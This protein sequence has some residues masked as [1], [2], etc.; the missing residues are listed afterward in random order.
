MDNTVYFYKKKSSSV[1]YL[2]LSILLMAILF[3][4]T[5]FMK[6]V[7]VFNR[8]FCGLGFLIFGAATL[9]MAKQT[10][11][12]FKKVPCIT[13]HNDRLIS[14]PQMDQNEN[15]V[16]VQFDEVDRLEY[17]TYTRH[18][19]RA[20]QRTKLHMIAVYSANPA[21]FNARNP[22]A[23]KLVSS[24]SRYIRD[25]I[26]FMIPLDGIVGGRKAAIEIIIDT[27][28]RYKSSQPTEYFNQ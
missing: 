9:V 22:N 15:Q 12:A 10:I 21:K 28:N 13:L 16:L 19:T 5:V 26:V 8:I 6:D 25:D 27:F 11:R 4:A 14:D 7:T 3:Y 2:I 17:K 24:L 20:H 18:S 23:R 1:G